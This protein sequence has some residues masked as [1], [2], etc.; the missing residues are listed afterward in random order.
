MTARD[1]ENNVRAVSPG[2]PTTT[3]ALLATLFLLAV[4]CAQP[5]GLI[6]SGDSDCDPGASCSE[7]QCQDATSDAFSISPTSATVQA[8]VGSTPAT[9]GFTLS[10]STKSGHPFSVACT[11]G[12]VEATL[13]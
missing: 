9:A 6:C 8:S 4:G 13:R 10:D 3:R 5:T 12:A 2:V 7:G 1:C 11:A